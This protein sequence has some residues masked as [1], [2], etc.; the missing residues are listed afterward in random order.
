M[1]L[2]Q[3]F[4]CRL[5]SMRRGLKFPR[6]RG[7][8]CGSIRITNGR[9]KWCLTPRIRRRHPSQTPVSS[10]TSCPGA[11]DRAADRAFHGLEGFF[12]HPLAGEAGSPLNIVG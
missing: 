2:R 1:P 4:A 6:M 7:S 3:Y 5:R 9:K 11:G 10:A 8:I 12:P